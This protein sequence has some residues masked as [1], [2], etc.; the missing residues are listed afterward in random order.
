MIIK[1]FT[2]L[3]LGI[4]I[5]NAQIEKKT[6]KISSKNQKS[7]TL[8]M[9]TVDYPPFYSNTLKDGGPLVAIVRAA[10]EKVG[11]KLKITYMPWK[12][13][14]SQSFK[15][16][17]DALFGC[18]HTAERA[19]NLLFSSPIL[20]YANR[21]HI[22]K[23]SLFTWD[24]SKGLKGLSARKIC[25]IRGYSIDP[26]FDKADYLIK[27]EVDALPQCMA[28]MEKK[29]VDMIIE[30]SLTYNYEFKKAYP[31]KPQN[32]K[33][34]GPALKTVSLFVGFSKKRPNHKEMV[35]KLNEGLRLIKEDGTF[36][37]IVDSF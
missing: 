4:S 32:Y 20:S 24:K 30:N 1:L 11:L 22:P 35:S 34:V 5:S 2:I 27:Q 9:V 25:L 14:V 8:R 31:N 36:K 33:L 16:K 3:I 21:F 7:K 23:D 6:N 13:A 37:K 26:E 18:L 15:G 28:M 10:L 29:R 19:K 12:R 17:F